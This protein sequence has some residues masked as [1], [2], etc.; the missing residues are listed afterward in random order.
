[1]PPPNNNNN[2]K[3]EGTCKIRLFEEVLFAKSI[4]TKGGSREQQERSPHHHNLKE[5]KVTGTEKR[6]SHTQHLP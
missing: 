2:N 4:L 6:E 5:E 1:M 3:T